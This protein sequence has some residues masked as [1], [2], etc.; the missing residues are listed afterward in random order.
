[1]LN[2]VRSTPAPESRDIWGV[3]LPFLLCKLDRL[4]IGN[5]F[6]V[7]TKWSKWVC[8]NKIA[9]GVITINVL[10]REPYPKCGDHYLGL[11]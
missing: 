11:T 7:D 5:I 8:F 2:L 1:M 6:C 10:V 9:N 3:N 4:V